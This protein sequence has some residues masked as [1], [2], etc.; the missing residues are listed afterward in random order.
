MAR[1]RHPQ[2][3]IEAALSYAEFQGWRVKE[4]GAHC[5]G[6]LYCPW[7]DKACRCGEFC[8]SCV[9]STPRNAQNHA[10]QIRRLVDGC[11]NI[12]SRSVLH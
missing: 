9:W 7:N 5:W 4:G 12:A 8:I 6:K 2:K 3:E 1:Q 11:A 10:R